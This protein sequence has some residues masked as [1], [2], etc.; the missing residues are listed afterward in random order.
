[1]QLERM[2]AEAELWEAYGEAESTDYVEEEAGQRATARA[3]LGRIEAHTEVGAL[4]D[5]GCW[6]GFLLSEAGA[7]GWN[8]LGVEPSGFA[9]A[10][11]RDRLG[12]DV[13]TAGLF[14]AKLPEGSFDAIFMG[15]VIEHIPAAGGAVERAGN[16]LRA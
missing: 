3:I 6:V 12:L 14:D 2:P 4:A 8:P 13:R 10:Y 15:D 16:L 5:L 9:S 7:R 1:M 11:A